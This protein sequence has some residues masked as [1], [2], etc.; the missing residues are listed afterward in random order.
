M[1]FVRGIARRLIAALFI[2]RGVR[3]IRYPEREGGA[4]A[5]L[6]YQLS[7]ETGM[8]DRPLG[9][10]RVGGG[11][12]VAAGVMIILGIAPR[13]AATLAAAILGTVAVQQYPFW[14]D[15]QSVDKAD[16]VEDFLTEAALVGGGLLIA[17]DTS[18]RDARR[19]ARR[20]A[21]KTGRK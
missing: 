2:A 15:R 16:V 18:R 14:V 10:V 8:P 12:L 17:A 20:L 13:L 4:I 21:R 9:I 3:W 6:V 5:P 11:K 7:K 19:A 1:R